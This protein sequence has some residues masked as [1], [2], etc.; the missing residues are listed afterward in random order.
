MSCTAC[1]DGWVFVQDG[2]VDRLAPVPFRE[3]EQSDEVYAALVAANEARRSALAR[4]VYPC[5]D[6]RPTQ[7]FRW[8]A[9]HFAGDHDRTACPDC[10]DGRVAGTG[11][12]RRRAQEP[13]LPE[14]P[15]DLDDGPEPVPAGRGD[16]WSETRRDLA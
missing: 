3:A 15:P 1:V 11:R 2:Y 8:A 14:P 4:T 12:R 7:F 5:K 9:G 16:D 10:R 6:C 13:P